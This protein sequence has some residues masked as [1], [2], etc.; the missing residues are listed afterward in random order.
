MK[1]TKHSLKIFLLSFI[2][3]FLIVFLSHLGVSPPR[4]VSPLE[5]ETKIDLMDE[6]KPK[7]RK[8]TE[9]F[10]LSKETSL[11]SE[12]RAGAEYASVAAYGVIDLN[13]GKVLNEKNIS[14]K[15]PIASLTKI[16]TAVVALD[17][18]SLE[19]VF[20]VSRNAASQIPTKVM[21]KE[22]EEMSLEHLLKALLIS[23]ANDSAEVI[24]EGIDFKYK[25]EVFIQSMN[26]KAKLLGLKNSNFVNP[27]GFDNPSHY[28]S[29]EDLSLL[30]FY[31]LKNY[32]FI[33]QIVKLELED[34]SQVKDE[35]FRLRNWNGL[36]GVYPG[37]FGFKTGNTNKAG[38]TAIVV[39]EREGNMLLAVVL[40]APGV[41][42][43][44]LWAAQL[45]D[46]GFEKGFGLKPM[47]ITE[48]SLRQKYDSWGF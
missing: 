6:I 36:L 12:A 27:Q 25:G 31:A 5:V 14:E 9:S 32:P 8:D 3:M 39:S 35:R 47:N 11:I 40:G 24:K 28:S 26:E 2:P 17:L 48:E 29:V 13:S 44:D 15:L 19:E 38:H 18:A 37:T 34:L 41:L 16:M 30:T 23:S 46:L 42:E 10:S 20:T 22:G 4:L 1:L 33:A 21:L 7:L 45:L 43:R